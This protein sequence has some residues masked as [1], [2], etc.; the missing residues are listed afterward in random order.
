M[1]HV[2]MQSD[3]YGIDIYEYSG[4][5]GA[6][7]RSKIHPIEN[8][9]PLPGGICHLGPVK[10]P[11]SI[12]AKWKGN[13]VT[14]SP[15]QFRIFVVALRCYTMWQTWSAFR[16][17]VTIN[18]VSC[19]ISDL[20]PPSRMSASPG[21][22][23]CYIPRWFFAPSPNSGFPT[24]RVDCL[25]NPILG[26]LN[27]QFVNANLMLFK[28]LIASCRPKKLPFWQPIAD[29]PL[30]PWLPKQASNNLESSDRGPNLT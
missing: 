25:P 3:S 30:I 14:G 24:D 15:L 10:S 11:S 7:E 21:T 12:T 6:G 28:N 26:T 17:A 19:F 13:H 27:S 29:G 23:P 16:F 22:C 5:M 20:P 18:A 2:I 4:W 8:C 9:N 1:E